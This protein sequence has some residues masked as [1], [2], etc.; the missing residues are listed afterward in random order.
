[1]PRH[2]NHPT[3]IGLRIS[4]AVPPESGSRAERDRSPLLV[5]RERR[6]SVG[7]KARSPVPISVPVDP[8]SVVRFSHARQLANLASVASI[9]QAFASR[10]GLNVC[11]FNPHM[12]AKPQWRTIGIQPETLPRFK[13]MPAPKTGN[14]KSYYGSWE[15]FCTAMHQSIGRKIESGVLT[16]CED[17]PPIAKKATR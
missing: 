17:W 16:F 6:G 13:V 1:M 8:M 3:L 2:A 14:W 12:T 4:A 7:G 9:E 5:A 10:C 11:Y 15:N